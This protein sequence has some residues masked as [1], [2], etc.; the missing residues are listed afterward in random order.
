MFGFF[1]GLLFGLVLIGFGWLGG[2]IYPAPTAITAPIAS[3]APDL[4]ARLGIDDVSLERLS[5]FMSVEQL[6]R[7]RDEASALAAAAGE[8]TIIE[9][10]DTQLAEQLATMSDAPAAVAPPVT[11]PVAFEPTLHV[12]PGMSV[13]NAPPADASRRVQRFARIVSVEG[14]RLAVNPTIGTCLSS[15]FGPRG[16][17]IHKGLDFH[18]AAG[19]P[20]LAAASGVV[21]ERKYRDDYGNMLLIDHG[22]GVYTRY[23]HLS[24]F[25]EDVI[26][27][28]H[29]EA[30]QRIGLMGN[31]ASYAIPIHLHYELLLGDYNNPRGS[32]G[33]TPR[34]PFEFSAAD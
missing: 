27:G 26:V 22:H 30:G 21:V 17:G 12:C 15:S 24:S 3:R 1:R 10:D 34:S 16:R 2:S 23:A 28:A 9:H 14:V 33:L 32:F 4:A 31:T 25:V 20:I 13:S 5:H 29:V 7:L 19:G 6:R 18:A 8:A 11:T